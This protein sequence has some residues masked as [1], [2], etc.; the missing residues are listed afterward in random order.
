MQRSTTWFDLPATAYF[1]SEK[2]THRYQGDPQLRALVSIDGKLDDDGP[3]VVN[4]IPVQGNARVYLRYRPGG[5]H[6]D[7]GWYYEDCT[8][9]RDDSD[10]TGKICDNVTGSMQS[11][12]VEAA[13]VAVTELELDPA[14]LWRECE[15]ERLEHGLEVLVKKLDELGEQ[16]TA[17]GTTLETERAKAPYTPWS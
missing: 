6:L 14:E 15:V 7:A 2:P 17:A 8:L 9:W 16:V 13:K 5:G 1:Y 12:L 4:G 10:S 11:K 3:L